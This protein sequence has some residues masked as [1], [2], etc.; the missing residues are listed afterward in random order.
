MN[1]SWN[2]RKHYAR[3]PEKQRR[4][5]ERVTYGSNFLS[6]ML[7]A[8]ERLRDNIIQVNKELNSSSSM[9][10]LVG[11][12]RADWNKLEFWCQVWKTPYVRSRWRYEILCSSKLFSK[13]FLPWLEEHHLLFLCIT[14]VAHTQY[15]AEIMSVHVYCWGSMLLAFADVLHRKMTAKATFLIISVG[16]EKPRM[17]EVDA[18]CKGCRNEPSGIF[19]KQP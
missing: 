7:C 14:P 10:E 15:K 9:D 12:Y 19:H 1:T 3:Y 18:V 4:L 11:P 5:T 17:G 6:A 8:G 16:T 2:K 13:C